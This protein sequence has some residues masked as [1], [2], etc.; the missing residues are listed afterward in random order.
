MAR[1]KETL[2]EHRERLGLSRRT[3]ASEAGVT[4]SAVWR[5]E[6][7]DKES[8]PD[9]LAH[10][11]T[12][13]IQLEQALAEETPEPAEPA[14]SPAPQR[15]DDHQPRNVG[16]AFNT[17]RRPVYEWVAETWNLRRVVNLTDD[18]LALAIKNVRSPKI[19]DD[20]R[21]IQEILKPFVTEH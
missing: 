7:S 20:L 3:L 16:P 6:Q 4:I 17:E 2:R 19:G 1:R 21:A 9:V 5:A 12:T 10:I 11:Q 13:L 8:S 18:K 14:P 15:A